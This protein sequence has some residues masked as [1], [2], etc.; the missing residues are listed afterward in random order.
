MDW[1][2]NLL[3]WLGSANFVSLTSVVGLAA[4][5]KAIVVPFVKWGMAKLGKTIEGVHTIIV[6]Y[7]FS[8]L[9]PVI[10]NG[11]MYGFTVSG[12]G[13]MVYVGIAAA[14]SAIGL[15]KTIAAIKSPGTI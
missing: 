6:V 5:I 15:Q 14:T 2:I 4:F 8:I 13:K 10:T 3:D 1:Y 9:I 7:V 11:C 12:V